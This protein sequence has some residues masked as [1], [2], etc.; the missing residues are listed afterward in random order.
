MCKFFRAYFSF[1][2]RSRVTMFLAERRNFMKLF[3]A[4][5]KVCAIDE[6]AMKKTRK[7]WLS[8]A[9]P[10][11]S[12][13]KLEDII[14]KI[15]GIKGASQYSIEKKALI[16]MCA[17]NGVVEEGVTQTGQEVTAVDRKSVV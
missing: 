7:Q 9:K 15:S 5:E 14:T 17:D 6:E 1:Q 2:V 10:L 8:I 12:L 3:E 13:G 11:F 4:I 16:V